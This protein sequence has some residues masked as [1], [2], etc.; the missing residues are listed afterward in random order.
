MVCFFSE[1][2]PYQC[3]VWVGNLM[4]PVVTCDNPGG[5]SYWDW[6]TPNLYIVTSQ[7]KYIEMFSIL[8]SLRS[9]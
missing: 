1:I 2:F 3:I 5:Q 8:L 7:N 6:A 4:T 9:G